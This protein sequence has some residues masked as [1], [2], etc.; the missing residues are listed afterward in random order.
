MPIGLQ[1]QTEWI[2]D[3]T[4]ASQEQWRRISND[5][6]IQ[7]TKKIMSSLEKNSK[8]LSNK[9]LRNVQNFAYTISLF[10]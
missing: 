2:N 4:I 3:E 1:Y 9:Q 10:Q 8:I 7:H 5:F 6:I